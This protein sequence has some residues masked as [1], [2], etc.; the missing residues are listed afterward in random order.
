MRSLNAPLWQ[1][2]RSLSFVASWIDCWSCNCEAVVFENSPAHG[3]K[4]WYIQVVFG[5]IDAPATDFEASRTE[6]I[7][8]VVD[9]WR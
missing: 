9:R 5:I 6:S 7:A 4:S 8:N 3:E 1:F 2:D